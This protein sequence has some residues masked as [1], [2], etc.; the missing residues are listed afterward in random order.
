MNLKLIPVIEIG[1]NN[2]DIK[3]PEKDPYWEYPED[4]DIYH[5]ECYKK[6]KFKD[7]LI[8]FISGSSLYELHKISDVNL[9]KI[10]ID[11]TKGLRNGEYKREQANPLFGGYA[12][13]INNKNLFYPQ[14]CGDLGDIQFWRNIS[15]GRESYYEGHPA[16]IVKFKTDK[17]LF[18]LNIGEFDE[19]FVPTPKRRKFSFKKGHLK[20]AIKEAELQL[21]LF[22]DRIRSINEYENLNI[23]RIEDL[24]VWENVNYQ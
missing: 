15:N 8:P 24:L 13:Q 1:Y 11:H 9:K 5:K 20:S 19:E 23:E 17:I 2:Q 7:D 16:P 18:D 4:W 14:C 6:A 22:A 3:I 21:E 10:V 12:L